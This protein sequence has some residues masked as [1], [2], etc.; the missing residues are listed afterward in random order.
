MILQRLLV[1]SLC[2]SPNTLEGAEPFGRIQVDT[3]AAT[4][5]LDRAGMLRLR[6]AALLGKQSVH[7]LLP[8]LLL[9][10][11]LLWLLLWLRHLLWRS[12]ERLSSSP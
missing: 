10:L 9:L 5:A 2:T 8:L 7:V 11:L 3:M 6:H 4:A 12:L 1:I